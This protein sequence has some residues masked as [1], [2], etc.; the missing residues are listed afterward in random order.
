VKQAYRELLRRSTPPDLEA[1]FRRLSRP[2]RALPLA[3]GL[4]AVL[5]LAVL[6][7]LRPDP[8]EVHLYVQVEGR[9]PV[10]LALTLES[11]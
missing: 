2:P 9:A 6:A 7:S 5:L 10:E 11:P 1:D 3:I 4:A 8:P